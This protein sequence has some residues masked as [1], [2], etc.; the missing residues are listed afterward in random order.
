MPSIEQQIRNGLVELRTQAGSAYVSPSFWQRIYLLWTFRHFHILPRQVL[1]RRQQELIDK[2]CCVAIVSQNPLVARDCIIGAVENMKVLPGHETKAAA[3]TNKV[4]EIGAIN[5][6]L[7]A[8]PAVG[9]ESISIRSNRAARHRIE[10]TRVTAK[11]SDVQCIPPLKPVSTEQHEPEEERAACEDSPAST[12]LNR[13]EVKW[14]LAAALVAVLVGTFFYF[15]ETRIAPPKKVA[16]I[17]TQL[18]R[19]ATVSPAVSKLPAKY[20]QPMT[21]VSILPAAITMLKPPPSVI[22]SGK[23]EGSNRK[24]VATDPARPAIENTDSAPRK[25]VEEAPEGGFRYPVAPSSVLT[26]K[27]SLKAIIDTNGTV[28][29]VD[30]LS[31]KR[32]LADAAVRAVRQWRYH[33]RQLGDDAIDAE[34]HI[35]ISFVGADAVSISFPPEH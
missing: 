12:T 16:G 7:A 9:S 11:N 2:L 24:G 8:S 23:R 17:T 27:V 22:P 34:T 4:V 33:A 5:T 26:G 13:D 18:P 31:G 14:A 28:K 32:A 3:S 29:E 1:S 35:V 6:E 25:L 15:R 10:I 21:E 30:V 19:V 20:R